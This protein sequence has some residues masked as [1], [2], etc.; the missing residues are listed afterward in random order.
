MRKSPV[1]VKYPQS[2]FLSK[3]E[4]NTRTF[5]TVG[6]PK[7]FS[8]KYLK[9]HRGPWAKRWVHT[10]FYRIPEMLHHVV[11]ALKLTI[12]AKIAWSNVAEFDKNWC[13]LILWPKVPRGVRGIFQEKD[14]AGLM[15]RLLIL[16]MLEGFWYSFFNS[17]ILISSINKRA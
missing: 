12:L 5:F 4:N 10:N 14:W 15:N 17:L 6:Q 9:L 8:E 3:D 1:V 2:L 7:S 11:E 16:F 13:A